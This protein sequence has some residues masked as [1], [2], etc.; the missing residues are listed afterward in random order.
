MST[1]YPIRSIS[2]NSLPPS[3]DPS[4]PELLFVGRSIE[5]KQANL[6]IEATRILAA[7]GYDIQLGLI[8][9]G[10]EEW[11]LR[12]QVA[13]SGLNPRVTFYGAIDAQADLWSLDSGT[14]VLLA[15]SI[16]EGFGLV[17][18]ESLAM[19]TPVVCVATPKMSPPIWSVPPPD[20]WSRR[21]TLKR[22]PTQP[23]TG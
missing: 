9:V 18:A 23:S 19:G 17:V 8:G 10:P 16:R 5:H 14:K 3:P 2:T 22:S 7:R 1:W 4:A 11:R 20:R 13:Y 15:P 6:A 21:L 12:D